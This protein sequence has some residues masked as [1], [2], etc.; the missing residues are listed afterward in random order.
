M[1]PATPS[2]WKTVPLPE[3]RTTIGLD[4]NF[5]LEELE[6][7]KRGVI[8]V[9]MEDKW[10]IY[11]END[12]LCFHR[13]WTGFC[14]YVVRFACDDEG[15]TAVRA[16]LN[17]DPEQYNNNDDQYDAEMIAYLVDVVLLRKPSRFPSQFSSDTKRA[18]EQWSQVGRAGLGQHPDD[19]DR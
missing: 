6:Q 5:S 7:I 9:E 1:K 16:D 12:T 3:E 19:E 2:D 13:S 17:R 8:P 11:W 18:M 14:V 15:A 4:R 10:F